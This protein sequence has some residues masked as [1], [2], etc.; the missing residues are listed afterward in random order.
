M[1]DTESSRTGRGG[2]LSP[3][4]RTDLREV[5]DA[6]AALVDVRV[7]RVWDRVA[8]QAALRD[9]WMALARAAA[10]DPGRCL[11]LLTRIREVERELSAAP[12]EPPGGTGV[13]GRA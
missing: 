4:Q 10:A 1:A 2:P 3:S 7:P 13:I 6:A 9:T 11:P 12:D 5:L 8:A